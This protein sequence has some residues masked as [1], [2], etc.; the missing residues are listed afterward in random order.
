MSKAVAQHKNVME[1]KRLEDEERENAF[2]RARKQPYNPVLSKSIVSSNS[3]VSTTSSA[4]S[5]LSDSGLTTAGRS[6]AFLPKGTLRIAVP[7]DPDFK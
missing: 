6:E 1:Q 7:T 2:N 4:V 3:A 5:D